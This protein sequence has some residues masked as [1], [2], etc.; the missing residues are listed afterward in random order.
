MHALRPA[1][2]ALPGIRKLAVPA[3]RGAPAY[4]ARD[5]FLRTL[6]ESDRFTLV[7]MDQAQAVVL[8]TVH[9][10]AFNDRG[11]DLRTIKDTRTRTVTVRDGDDNV[12]RSYTEEVP[13]KRLKRYPYVDRRLDMQLDMRVSSGSRTLAEDHVQQRFAC[14]YG[15]RACPRADSD[16]EEGHEP[17]Q[18][19]PPLDRAMDDLACEAARDLAHRLI[20]AAYEMTVA[21]AEGSDPRVKRGAELADQDQWGAA[22]QLW[23]AVLAGNP[24]DAASL[25][26]LGVA[27]ERRGRLL[28]LEQAKTYYTRAADL[29][30]TD[31][32]LTARQRIEQRLRDALELQRRM[33]IGDHALQGEPGDKQTTINQQ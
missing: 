8:V 28:D 32:F 12:V 3:F 20:P 9:G 16:C 13:V 31:L 10:S 29:A 5:C 7:P 22:M 18:D 17:L 2:V 23:K 27:L 26:N 25:Y 6:N 14:R 21:L 19:M 33:R 11:V 4:R 24:S 1:E 15:G 30:P